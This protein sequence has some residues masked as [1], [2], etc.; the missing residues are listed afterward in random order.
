MFGY[1]FNFCRIGFRAKFRFAPGG[2]TT[3]GNSLLRR[4]RRPAT[5]SQEWQKAEDP[6]NVRA[7]ARRVVSKKQH[8][9]Q[10]NASSHGS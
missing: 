6:T 9:V 3:S 7:S 4:G 8:A 10:Q 5:L 2:N 1:R